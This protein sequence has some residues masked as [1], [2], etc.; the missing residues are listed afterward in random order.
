MKKYHIAAIAGLF[1]LAVHAADLFV[2]SADAVTAGSS[3]RELPTQGVSLT[4]G[5]VVVG[6]HA[7][8]D[9]GRADCGWYRYSPGVKPEAHSNEVWKVDGYIF[10][11]YTATAQY[12]CSWRKVKP[13]RFSKLSIIT[14]LEKLPG[15]Q[16][17]ASA[18]VTVRNAISAR[19][20]MDKWNACT[21]IEENHEVF[22]EYKAQ[23]AAIAGLSVAE[24]DE[25]L[26]RCIY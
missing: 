18:W 9:A 1:A 10:T 14:E 15:A 25:I 17:D 4:T 16:G 19:G 2:F 22:S 11:N 6:L 3:P 7:L 23:I 12:T 5:K 13:R 24:I 21:Y 8:D 26:S 20:L